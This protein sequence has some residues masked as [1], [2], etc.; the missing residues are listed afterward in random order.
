MRTLIGFRGLFLTGA[1]AVA[2]GLGALLSTIIYLQGSTHIFSQRADMA[3]KQ[4]LLLARI[5]AE[6]AQILLDHSSAAQNEL[7]N[8]VQAYF[9]SISSETALMDGTASEL[10]Y[11][12]E[13]EANARHLVLLLRSGSSALPDI[14]AMVR[15]IA[16]KEYREAEAAT[17][18]AQRTQH[19]AWRLILV[20]SVALLALPLGGA[21]FL[22]WHLVKPLE[23]VAHAT[24]SI[25]QEDG[26]KPLPGSRLLE[27]RRLID[28]FEN[29]AQAVEAKVAVRTGELERL[30]RQLAETDQRRRLFLSKVSHELR[31]PVTV[32][33]GEAE[34]ALRVDD[35]ISAL[36]DALHQIL[37]SNLFLERRLND[38][39]TLARAEDGALPLRSSPVD[40]AQLAQQVGKSAASFASASGIRLEL[41]SLDEP[42]PVI[43][44]PDRLRQAMLALIDNGVK[45]SPP[46]ATLRLSGTY[47]QGEVG[48]IVTDEGPGVAESELDR[49]FDPYVQGKAGRSLGGTGLGLS[50]ARWIAQA[51]AG[52][53]SANN[54]YDGEGLCV[55]LRLP[56]RA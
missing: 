5:D 13:E 30:N 28:H 39:L 42:M 38:L 43:G 4:V 15:H 18:A 9:E 50:L 48:I 29:M 8:A 17:Q 26:R 33:R 24:R 10:R 31:T 49:I 11:Q 55:S 27:V 2:I 52:G 44:D 51:H 54:R 40:L 32:M 19:G 1:V 56:A 23:A 20:I 14:R 53:I 16:A 46:G 7:G 35:N 34:I 36:R 41:A 47:Q 3:Q 6:A 12:A 22:W 25:A 37:D 45:F 21:A